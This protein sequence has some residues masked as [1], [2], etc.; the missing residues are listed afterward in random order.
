MESRLVK[1]NVKHA[2]GLGSHRYRPLSQSYASYFRLFSSPLYYL[3][4]RHRLL[5]FKV[6]SLI[7][8]SCYSFSF[9]TSL[10]IYEFICFTIVITRI[11][12]VSP[13]I[14]LLFTIY[15]SNTVFMVDEFDV[16][17]SVIR[18][19]RPQLQK[20]CVALLFFFLFIKELL[21]V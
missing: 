12:N 16:Y 7:A 13:L 19:E 8:W 18:K 6:S 17:V 5:S 21:S 1:R 3:R 11:S 9:F 4:A 14:F 10:T 20:F 2:R 15:T